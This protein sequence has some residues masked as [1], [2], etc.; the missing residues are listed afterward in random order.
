MI[1]FNRSRGQSLLFL[2]RGLLLDR[3]D[4]AIAPARQHGLEQRGAILEA[5]VE[6]ALGD[7]EILRQHLDPHAVDAAMG[8]FGKAGGDPDIA[9]AFS[10]VISAERP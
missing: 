1:A 8:E 7:A 6:A 5:A 10:H 4:A 3:G 9:L 2:E